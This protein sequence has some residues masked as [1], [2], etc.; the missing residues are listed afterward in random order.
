[1]AQDDILLERI[2]PGP[3]KWYRSWGL[4]RNFPGVSRGEVEAISGS[5]ITGE[6]TRVL[7]REK[8]GTIGVTDDAVLVSDGNGLAER[9]DR[10]EARAAV[11]I[12]DFRD[13]AA[14]NAQ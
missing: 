13:T 6:T 3:Y 5:T 11:G 7:D 12:S 1:M 2:A 14:E 4:G 10:D 8:S 9:V